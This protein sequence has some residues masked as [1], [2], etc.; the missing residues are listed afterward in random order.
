M[1][2]E[3]AKGVPL[4]TQASAGLKAIAHPA[5]LRMLCALLDGDRTVSELTALTGLS[6]S[7]VSQH[8]ARMV[9]AGVLVNR[10]LGNQVFYAVVDLRYRALVESLCVIYGE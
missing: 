6:Q 4:L 10:R 3:P 7:G 2:L 9:A 5:R 8:L 1:R